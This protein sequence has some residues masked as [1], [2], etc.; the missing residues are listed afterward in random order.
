[1]ASVLT[2]RQVP[3]HGLKPDGV[4]AVYSAYRIVLKAKHVSDTVTNEGAQR[5]V[6]IA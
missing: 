3:C 2:H 4:T 1:M 5:C 6:P